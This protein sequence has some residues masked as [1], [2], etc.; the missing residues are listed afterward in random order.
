M[1]LD[2]IENSYWSCLYNRGSLAYGGGTM[3]V[4]KSLPQVEHLA[5]R[6]LCSTVADCRLQG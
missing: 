5:M 4:S 1:S 3:A 2:D 6:V